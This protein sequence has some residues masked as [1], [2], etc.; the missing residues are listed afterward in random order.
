MGNKAIKHNKHKFKGDY[1]K[2]F[3]LFTIVLK[4]GAFTFGGGY[5]M[6]PLM[7]REYVEKRQWFETQEMLDML[8]V[9]QSLPGMISINASILVGYRLFGIIG[10]LVAVIGL[11]LPSLIVLSIISFFY[12]KFRENIYVNTALKGIR[13]AV[14]ALLVQ[15]VIKLGKPGVRGVFGWVMA[16]AAFL[17]AL[18]FSIH[19]V[20]IILGGLL[21][22]IIYT[23]FFVKKEGDAA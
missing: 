20:L 2:L 4:L 11:A 22:G 12:V 10:S 16:C 18:I 17:V 19:P 7:E 5:A 23:Q 3:E 21:V 6:F 14:V 8:A 15:A 13:V 9:A 1:K